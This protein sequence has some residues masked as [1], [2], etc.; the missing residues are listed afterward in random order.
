[1]SLTTELPCFE[2]KNSLILLDDYDVE[3]RLDAL[4]AQVVFVLC[5]P[6]PQIFSS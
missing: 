2:E 4:S 5:M 1:M 3:L 6:V